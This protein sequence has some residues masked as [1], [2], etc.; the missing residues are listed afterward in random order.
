MDFGPPTPSAPGSSPN[1]PPY[2]DGSNYHSW[3]KK[4]T[5][6]IQ[7]YN[8]K[9]WKVIVLG[10]KIPKNED[11]TIKEYK[12][13][14]D[15]DWKS[16]KLSSTATQLLYCALSS[17]EFNRISSCESAKE[18]WEMLEVTHEGTTQVK[19]TKVNMLLHDYELFTMRKDESINNMLDRFAEITNGLASFGRPISSSDR[20][21]KILRSLPQ[22]WD[23]M[24]TAIM[25][26]KDLNSLEFSALVGSLINYEIVL[27]SRDGRPKY[28]KA[29]KASTHLQKD[30]SEGETSMDEEEKLYIKRIATYKKLLK[31]KKNQQNEMERWKEKKKKKKIRGYSSSSS[32]DGDP[33]ANVCLSAY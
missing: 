4:M 6:F 27:K 30:E 26:S 2:F 3:K 32:D 11:G 21:K 17:E 10:P 25:E 23:A 1:S 5:I 15:E 9:L 24:V 16:L 31:N 22:E 19:E 33:S 28:G 7:A 29:L 14:K 18:I 8:I 13:F 12:D 20:V